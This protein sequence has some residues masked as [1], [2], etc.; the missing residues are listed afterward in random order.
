MNVFSKIRQSGFTLV[1][2]LIGVVMLA[3]LVTF[4]MPNFRTWTLNSQIRNAAESIQNGLQRARGEAVARNTN[5][6]FAL[7]GN[8]ASCFDAVTLISS[9]CSS[10]EVRLP[11]SA[12]IDSR[13]S[14]E[15][16]K[17]V[18]R[19][20]TPAG[21][22]TVT[23]NSLGLLTGNSGAAAA[24]TMVELDSTELASSVSRELD[25]MITPIGSVRMC[26]PH[27]PAHSMGAC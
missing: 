27:A 14:S 23:F 7:L 17:L 20:V 2:L 19:T 12:V 4:A 8:D 1:E 9:T 22:T 11:G 3:I 18:R 6:E 16:S 21:A 15:G 26:D 5:V 10:W 13:S 25:I 24:I